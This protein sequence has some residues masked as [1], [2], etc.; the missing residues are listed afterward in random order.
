MAR[1]RSG[2]LQTGVGGVHLCY[3]L[4][5]RLEIK[6]KNPGRSQTQ[7]RKAEGRG[8]GWGWGCRPSCSELSPARSLFHSPEG[9][10]CG[11]PERVNLKPLCAFLSVPESCFLHPQPQAHPTW[12][13]EGGT[14]LKQRDFVLIEASAN[15]TCPTECVHVFGRGRTL[16]PGWPLPCDPG[17]SMTGGLAPLNLQ[18]QPATRSCGFS[19]RSAQSGVK[20]E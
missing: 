5:C 8:P 13:P 18:P 6:L 7:K 19:C 4:N 20:R 16:D 15:P 12:L 9:Q 3:W 11:H 17:R 10:D 2:T 1:L 14:A